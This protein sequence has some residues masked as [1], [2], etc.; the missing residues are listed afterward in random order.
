MT[1]TRELSSQIVLNAYVLRPYRLDITFFS[2]TEFYPD[3]IIPSALSSRA[4]Q[5]VP[6]IK[7]I[8]AMTPRIPNAN[9]HI[10]F[11]T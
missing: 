3:K 2:L 5:Y 9:L 8:I 4:Q 10:K 1:S 6:I 7:L 11:N